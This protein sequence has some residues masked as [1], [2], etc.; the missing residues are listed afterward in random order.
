MNRLSM[1]LPPFDPPVSDA[2]LWRASRA[3]DRDAFGRIV[4]R[5]QSLVASVAYSRTG[6]LA[7]AADFAQETFVTAW[8]SLDALRE[9]AL[10]KSWLAG[11][12]RNLTAN[13]AQ[14]S[15]RRGGAPVALDGIAEPIAREASPEARAVS[16]QE[17]ELLWNTLAELPESYREPLVLFY[18]EERSIAE[19]ANQLELSED[20]VKQ[21]LS[22][23]RAL[24]KAEMSALVESALARSRPGAG[25]TAGVLAAIALTAPTSAAVAATVSGGAAAAG[26]TGAAVGKGT[27]AEWAARSSPARPPVS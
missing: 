14:R 13:A 10:L 26:A 20:A 23:G 3:G 16:K 19:V 18:R 12:A 25:F 21:R 8:R 17:E 5:Y 4:E 7:A 11:I 2:E 1:P 22:R 24:L 6:D 15:A 9:P 27:S